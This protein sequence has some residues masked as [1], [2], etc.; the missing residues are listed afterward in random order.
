MRLMSPFGLLSS[1]HV[2]G[3]AQRFFLFFWFFRKLFDP[4]NFSAWV[5]WNRWGIQGSSGSVTR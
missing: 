1:G 5:W 4:R 2:L 3:V